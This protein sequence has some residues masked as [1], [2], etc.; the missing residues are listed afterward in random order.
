MCFDHPFMMAISYFLTFFQTV[1]GDINKAYKKEQF[2]F[3]PD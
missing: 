3:L 2:Q 1:H